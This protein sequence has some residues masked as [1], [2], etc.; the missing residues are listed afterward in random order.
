[1][2][3]VDKPDHSKLKHRM[4][5]RKYMYLIAGLGNPGREYENTRHNAGFASID[6]L[7]G[8][9]PYFQLTMTKISGAVRYRLYRRAE[10]A[11]SKAA[12]VYEFKR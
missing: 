11:A 7:G 4:L 1:M 8:E 6:R 9:E 12:D 3:A 5:R 2:I 10:G